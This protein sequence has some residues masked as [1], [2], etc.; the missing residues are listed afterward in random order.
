MQLF[1][2]RLKETFDNL[3]IRREL[4]RLSRAKVRAKYS[5]EMLQI[6]LRFA[7]KSTMF[8]CSTC[9][10]AFFTIVLGKVHFRMCPKI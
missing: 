4:S 5:N 7:H 6:V 10:C 9:S 8:E 3:D 2:E 1:T